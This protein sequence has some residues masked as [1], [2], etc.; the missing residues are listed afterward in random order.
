M[1][2]FFISADIEGIA[3]VSTLDQMGPEKFEYGLAR[4]WMTEEVASAAR[5]ALTSGYDEVI[6]GDGHGNAQNILIDDLP[7]EA[8]LIRAAREINDH[9]P[10]WVIERVKI[11][12][13][14]FLTK[15]SGKTAADIKVACF[16]LAFKAN[17]DDLRESPAL[18]ITLDL[19]RQLPGTVL[20]VEPH[21]HELPPKLADAGIKLVGTGDAIA[22]ADVLVLLV[23]HKLFKDLQI[24]KQSGKTMVDTRGIWN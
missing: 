19:A 6:I 22:Q 10:E 20:A 14:D 8:K 7:E 9:K 11:A 13:A 17:I 12:I 4:K 1:K 23:D 18:E 3:G 5:T 2:K 16:G 21:I 15:N 24:T